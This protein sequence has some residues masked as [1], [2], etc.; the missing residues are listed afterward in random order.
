[1]FP[2]DFASVAEGIS[3]DGNRI[4]GYSE[5]SGPPK[6]AIWDGANGLRNL[7][8]MLIDDFELN[9]NGWLLDTAYAISTDGKTIVGVGINPQGE[10]EAFRAVIPEPAT[11]LLALA[12]ILVFR[13]RR[14][15]L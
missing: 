7:R 4:V 1:M 5:G 11:A 14:R 6:A 12:A 3:G 8:Q 2:G 13:P 9:L 10:R 15:F